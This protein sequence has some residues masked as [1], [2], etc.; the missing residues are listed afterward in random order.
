MIDQESLE[1]YCNKL[2]SEAD[3]GMFPALHRSLSC[4]L[5]GI[6]T[7]KE[8]VHV[9]NMVFDYAVHITCLWCF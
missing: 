8:L 2:T 9:K 3:F 5:H 1:N 4:L 6:Y 7:H